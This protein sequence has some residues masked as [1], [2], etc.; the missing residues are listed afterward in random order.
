MGAPR[1]PPRER[2]GRRVDVSADRVFIS[3]R[4]ADSGGWARSLHD[5][6]EEQLGAGRA[7]RD[8]AMEGGMDFVQHVES[9]LD[10]C[11]VLLAII[12]KHWVS[13]ADADGHRR[14][15]DPDDL[16]RREIARALQRPDVQVIPVLVG[17]AHMPAKDELPPDLAPLI[18]RQACELTDSRW[19]YDVEILTRRVRDLLG[20]KPR[21]RSRVGRPILWAAAIAIVLGGSLVLVLPALRSEGTP[22]TRAA[23]LSNPTLDRNISFGQYLDRKELSRGSYRP[24]A[25]ARSGV[26]VSFDFRIQGYRG[27]RLPLRWQLINTGSGDQVAQSRDVSIV[28]EADD[29]QGTWDVWVPVPP[30]A[31]QRY[32]VQVQLYDSDGDVPIARLR[33]TTFAGPG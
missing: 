21:R 26:L 32:F 3:Y 25:L 14:L 4:R 2:E 28:P 17:G 22:A 16:V 31:D 1:A 15:D 10:R 19:D 27:E 5:K 23:S 13:I 12:G 33:T 24:A 30:G 7:F 11:D 8:V 18:Q 6:L 29:D 9:L 20:E